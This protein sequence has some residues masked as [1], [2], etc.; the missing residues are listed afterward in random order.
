[1]DGRIADAGKTRAMVALDTL[2]QQL[3]RLTV[4]IAELET[5][6]EQRHTACVIDTM[7]TI[8][9]EWYLLR[10]DLCLLRAATPTG[11]E[12]VTMPPAMRTVRRKVRKVIRWSLAY[13]AHVASQE[14]R[15]E[16]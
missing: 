1:V 15:G 5:A 16:R 14:P 10:A 9:A 8:T 2:L 13:V 3:G 6:I 7:R 4:R 11:C 12:V